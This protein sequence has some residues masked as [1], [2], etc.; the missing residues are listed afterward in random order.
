MPRLISTKAFAQPSPSCPFYMLCCLLK[1]EN[2]TPDLRNDITLDKS[3]YPACPGCKKLLGE[4]RT[5][6]ISIHQLCQSLQRRGFTGS[7]KGKFKKSDKSHRKEISGLNTFF[8]RN[9]QSLLHHSLQDLLQLIFLHPHH[10][11]DLL[12]GYRSKR[13]FCSYFRLLFCEEDRQY[14][15]KRSM[16]WKTDWILVKPLSQSPKNFLFP[17]KMPTPSSFP[18]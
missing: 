6:H 18:C 12:D 14:F 1:T 10:I 8:R 13:K 15:I 17:C 11:L 16:F 7:H 9:D 4:F 3:S 5:I 2:F